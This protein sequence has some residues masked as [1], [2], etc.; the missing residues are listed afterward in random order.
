M[1]ECCRRPEHTPEPPAVARRQRPLGRR[2][3]TPSPGKVPTRTPVEAV[4]PRF[5]RPPQRWRQGRRRPPPPQ[6][7]HLG[8]MLECCRRLEHAPEPPPVAAWRGGAVAPRG[9]LPGPDLFALRGG[10]GLQNR[11]R[12][13]PFRRRRRLRDSVRLRGRLGRS[14]DGGWRLRRARAGAPRSKLRVCVFVARRPRRLPRGF[15]PSP[16]LE[17]RRGCQSLRKRGNSVTRA[18]G[19]E[20]NAGPSEGGEGAQHLSLG[21]RIRA[22][23]VVQSQRAEYAQTKPRG[24]QA[25]CT[26][27]GVQKL[28]AVGQAAGEWLPGLLQPIPHHVL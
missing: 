17:A 22:C 3:G 9:F 28:W 8:A 23:P 10:Q 5:R 21:P 26:L 20:T 4:D 13:R 2:R 24:F 14:R 19:D 27:G 15:L 11:G 16:V 18:T 25:G 1:L 6:E 7:R 12:P